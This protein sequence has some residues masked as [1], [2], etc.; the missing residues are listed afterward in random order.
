MGT[1]QGYNL[2]MGRMTIDDLRFLC[3]HESGHAVVAQRAGLVIRKIELEIELEN[4]DGYTFI[5]DFDQARPNIQLAVLLSGEE[6]ERQI[7]G[8]E[9]PKRLLDNGDQQRVGA[10]LALLDRRL[11][12]SA[13][14][15]A[16]QQS[17]RMVQIHRGTILNVANALMERCAVAGGPGAR[18]DG[19]ALAEVLG[20]P[21]VAILRA[22]ARS[23]EAG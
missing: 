6:S 23:T 1:P 4:L 8:A 13:L 22:A 19:A 10:V 20:G 16:R 21:A 17:K 3:V 11:W 5:A 12:T 15:Q 7:L 9:I 2:T 14:A 18:L